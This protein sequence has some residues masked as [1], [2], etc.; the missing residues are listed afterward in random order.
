[1]KRNYNELCKS[2]AKNFYVVEDNG[3]GL[4]LVIYNKDEDI[5]YITNEFEYHK[6]NLI[7]ALE[8]LSYGE[9]HNNWENNLL[10]DS[11][12]TFTMEN[13]EYLNNWFPDEQYKTGW[14]I[15]ADNNG[16]YPEVMGTAGRLEFG[17][18]ME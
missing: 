12:I 10:Y 7:E 11:D 4:T 15:I 14:N 18:R 3:G 9:N 2:I 8:K 17:I 6:G 5:E 16:I 1:M 13:P